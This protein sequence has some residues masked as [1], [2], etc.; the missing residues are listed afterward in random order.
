MNGKFRPMSMHVYVARDGWKATPI[1][2]D[3]WMVIMIVLAD[4]FKANV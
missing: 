4:I 2:E 3:E 1:L